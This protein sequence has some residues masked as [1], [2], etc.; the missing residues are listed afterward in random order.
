[1]ASASS[2]VDAFALIAP[3]FAPLTV[4]GLGY[5]IYTVNWRTLIKDFFLGPGRNSRLALVVFVAFNLKNMP[6][7][8][9]V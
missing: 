7:A 1:M 3:V 5:A 8:W 9:T 4:G 6:F 2:R